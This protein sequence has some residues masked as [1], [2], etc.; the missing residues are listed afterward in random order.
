MKRLFLAVLLLTVPLAA[1]A[2]EPDEVLE[3]PALED[4]ARAVEE[5]LEELLQTIEEEARTGF[6]EVQAPPIQGHISFAEGKPCLAMTSTG[7]KGK[8]AICNLL[9]EAKAGHYRLHPS[10]LVE[11]SFLESSFTTILL[12]RFLGES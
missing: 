8:A 1:A 9:A 12:E 11:P 5:T 6:L 3:D 7:L 10:E 2:V 4:R